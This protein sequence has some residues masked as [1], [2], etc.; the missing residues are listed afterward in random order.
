MRLFKLT[1]HALPRIEDPHP[2]VQGVRS[3]THAPHLLPRHCHLRLPRLLR[4]TDPVQ[5]QQPLHIHPRRTLVGHHDNRGL[6]RDDSEDISGNVCWVALLS[7]HGRSNHRTSGSGHRQQFR[8]VAGQGGTDHLERKTQTNS[9][10]YPESSARSE[11]DYECV[12]ETRFEG[13]VR[14]HCTGESPYLCPLC[15]MRYAKAGC[16]KRHLK[17][18][19]TGRLENHTKSHTGAKQYMCDRCDKQFKQYTGLKESLENAY[20]R[21]TIQL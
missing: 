19:S 7:G 9:G 17:S 10:K 6:R 18:H 8:V 5:P 4:R 20:R 12:D 16:L 2:H 15:D 21:K 3:R 14:Q 13:R 1:P 11:C